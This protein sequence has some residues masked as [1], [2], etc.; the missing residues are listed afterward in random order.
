MNERQKIEETISKKEQEIQS[1]DEKIR[2]AKVYVKALR[3]VLNM[4]DR[5]GTAEVAESTLRPGSLVAQARDVILKKGHPAH[6]SNLLSAMGKEQTREARASLASSLA[7]YVRRG[8]IFVRTAPNTFGLLELGHSAESAPR[9]PSP[10]TGFGK[11]EPPLAPPPPESENEYGYDT[12]IG[13][14]DNEE[15]PF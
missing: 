8:D 5:D 7:A 13:D 3:D 1:L 10:P 14:D 4:L 12:H 2:A 15:T 6:I 9:V 11:L